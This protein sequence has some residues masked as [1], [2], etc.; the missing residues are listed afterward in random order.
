MGS[1]GGVGVAINCPTKS[2][3]FCSRVGSS[4]AACPSGGRGGVVCLGRGIR[5][6]S[7][8]GSGGCGG[9]YGGG[10]GP[11]F[12]IGPFHLLPVDV[13]CACC[14]FLLAGIGPFHLLRPVI[15]ASLLP[16]AALP[17]PGVQADAVLPA[18]LLDAVLL[19]PDAVPSLARIRLL[20]SARIPLLKTPS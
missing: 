14:L 4:A 16:D 18:P 17:A 8:F 13:R 2:S 15:T 11:H 20:A 6:G 9:G 5:F 12:G 10:F 19:L 1:G 7:G 3:I